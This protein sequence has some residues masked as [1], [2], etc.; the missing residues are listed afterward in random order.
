MTNE[1]RPAPGELIESKVR[2]FVSRTFPAA[3]K[4][5]IRSNDEWLQ[6]GLIDS[7]GV[8]DLVQFLEKEF[9]IPISDEEL[10]PDNFQSLHAVVSFVQ[11]KSAG[12]G[13]PKS[14]GVKTAAN[15]TS[16][17]AHE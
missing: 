17:K 10:L 14:Q 9:S 16:N 5:T 2:D 6:S 1:T 4:Q 13:S 8:L 3:R 11:R 12:S 7:L 15:D